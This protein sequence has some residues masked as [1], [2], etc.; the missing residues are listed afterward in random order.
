MQPVLGVGA[1]PRHKSVWKIR[2]LRGWSKRASPGLTAA[3]LWR[4][5]VP[6]EEPL[7]LCPWPGCGAGG[8]HC[9][10]APRQG[11]HQPARGLHTLSRCRAQ[12]WKAQQPPPTV[13]QTSLLPTRCW[14]PPPPAEKPPSSY[15]GLPVLGKVANPLGQGATLVCSLLPEHAATA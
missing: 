8:C 15:W 2:V 7:P 3:W 10:L 1:G 5:K 9:T 4:V 11:T 6:E 12:G 13:P 14:H